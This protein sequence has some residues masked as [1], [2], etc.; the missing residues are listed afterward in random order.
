MKNSI[1]LILFACIIFTG[2]KKSNVQNSLN[3]L[4]AVTGA[5][6]FTSSSVTAQLTPSITL[7]GKTQLTI[8]AYLGNKVFL[9]VIPDYISSTTSYSINLNTA[10]GS[11]NDGTFED[12]FING[13]F[14]ITSANGIISG[15]FDLYTRTS[16]HITNGMFTVVP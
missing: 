5:S 14:M 15:T 7:P 8:T 1:L 11:Y 10:T 2:C 16:V 12:V 9:I 6:S 3:S 4:S 13:S